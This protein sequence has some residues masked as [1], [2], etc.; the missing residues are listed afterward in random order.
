MLSMLVSSSEYFLD[1]R[2]ASR[3]GQQENVPWPSNPLILGSPKMVK[4]QWSTLVALFSVP[5]VTSGGAF[6]WRAPLRGWV[7]LQML[8]TLRPGA[9]TQPATRV[10]AQPRERTA[11]AEGAEPRL[12]H[13]AAGLGCLSPQAR[14]PSLGAARATHPG[15]RVARR[16]RATPAPA[17]T[18]VAHEAAVRRA[19]FHALAAP[20]R[21]R[22]GARPDRAPL[23]QVPEARRRD[24]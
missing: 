4:M 10:G 1:R 11:G 7:G 21:R 6:R 18:H 19:G 5:S 16:R 22:A 24:L 3:S 12:R 23:G 15:A 8:R 17:R 2:A 14:P 13:W 9:A 20:G